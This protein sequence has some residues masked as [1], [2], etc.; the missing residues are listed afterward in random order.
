MRDPKCLEVG[1]LN[2]LAES[3]R[4]LLL[5]LVVHR[6][7]VIVLASILVDLNRI[8]EV[9]LLVDDDLALWL[10]AVGETLWMILSV[11]SLSR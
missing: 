11:A 3:L 5:L 4:I 6:V 7:L 9:M 10:L 8:C 2:C 1:G